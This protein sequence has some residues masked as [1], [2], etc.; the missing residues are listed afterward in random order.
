MDKQRFFS[1]LKEYNP[2]WQGEKASTGLINR[3]IYLDRIKELLSRREIIVLTGIR[4]SGKSSLLK[5]LTDQLVESGVP[6]ENIL[7]IN[8]EDYRFGADKDVYLLEN[9]YGAFNETLN[10]QG[11]QYVFLD[12]I[13]E[14]DSFEKW[15][16][17]QYEMRPEIKFIVTGSSSTITSMEL[18]SLLTG[19]QIR[20]DIYPFSFIE[21]LTFRNERLFTNYSK[22][23]ISDLVIMNAPKQMEKYLNEYLFH[24]GFPEVIINTGEQTNVLLLQQ[25]L[26]DILLKDIS[27]RYN[28]RKIRALQSLTHFLISNISNEVNLKRTASL[29]GINRS[30]LLD[31]ISYLKE[32]Y[33]LFLVSNF[34]F[35]I[36]ERLNTTKPKKVYCVDNGFFTAVK[37]TQTED[38]GKRVENLV[39]QHLKFY[40]QAEVFYWK[41]KVEIDFVL[42][43]GFPINV[44]YNDDLRE[45]ELVGLFY[46]LS[47]FNQ[48]RG[49][50]ISMNKFDRIEQDDHKVLILPL[51]IFLLKTRQE[52]DELFLN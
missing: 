34:S 15:L 49:M 41:S 2:Q 7:N 50:L 25:Y 38:M 36:K 28:V 39:F 9:L 21:F 43:N 14:V 8:L 48:K 37:Q 1:I 27:V 45:R 29:L 23:K 44:T 13:Q 12:E 19:R 6:A 40:W 30:T 47:Q 10:P 22:K 20:I 46:Y 24:G 16:R 52:V 32:V 3:P 33:L 51:W 18:A 17:T 26:D 42:E 5:L 4:R 31:L 11:R 35:S